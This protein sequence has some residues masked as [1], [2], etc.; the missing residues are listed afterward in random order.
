MSID[1][2]D[3]RVFTESVDPSHASLLELAKALLGATSTG[4]ADEINPTL[5]LIGYR[6]FDVEVVRPEQDDA[7]RVLLVTNDRVVGTTDVSVLPLGDECYLW[8]KT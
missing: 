7:Q 6:V 8:R 4:R 1:I 2:D 3:P 5:Y